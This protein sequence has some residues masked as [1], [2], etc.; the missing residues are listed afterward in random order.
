MMLKICYAEKLRFTF[1]DGPVFDP[2]LW[3]RNEDT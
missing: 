3:D 2:K 1:I